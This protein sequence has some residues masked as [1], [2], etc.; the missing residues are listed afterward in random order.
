MQLAAFCA[1]EQY[2]LVWACWLGY[3]VGR[4]AK[5]AKLDNR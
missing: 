1:M 3:R 4:K 2:W 5:Q